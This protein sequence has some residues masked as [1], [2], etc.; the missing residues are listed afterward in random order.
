MIHET[1]SRIYSELLHIYQLQHYC[2]YH[3]QSH[4]SVY[5]SSTY[6]MKSA[7]VLLLTVSIF[8]MAMPLLC[9]FTTDQLMRQNVNKLQS[10]HHPTSQRAQETLTMNWV[11]R[12]TNQ[13]LVKKNITFIGI[14]T[15]KRGCI[16]IMVHLKGTNYFQRTDCWGKCLKYHFSTKVSRS[17][18]FFKHGYP[19]KITY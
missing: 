12:Q 1:A 14:Y 15:M 4:I 8:L 16:N 11:Q 7:M 18:K 6:I 5:N 9:R 19:P 17:K 3:T 2:T 10:L 13:C